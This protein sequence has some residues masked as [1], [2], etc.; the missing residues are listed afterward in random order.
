[1]SSSNSWTTKIQ[2]ASIEK[3]DDWLMV[4]HKDTEP[5]KDDELDFVIISNQP[6]TEP[7]W[8]KVVNKN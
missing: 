1:M 4:E 8:G 7:V 2:S 5:E 6:F 3:L